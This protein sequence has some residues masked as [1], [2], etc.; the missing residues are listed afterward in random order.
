MIIKRELIANCQRLNDSLQAVIIDKLMSKHLYRTDAKI[1]CSMNDAVNLA[2]QNMQNMLSFVKV[3][4]KKSLYSSPSTLNN[5]RR[6][7][8]SNKDT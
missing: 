2:N 4:T 7:E 8:D 3:L 5:I 6:L 1:E